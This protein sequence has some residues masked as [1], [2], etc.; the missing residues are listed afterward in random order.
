[1]LAAAGGL[2]FLTWSLRGIQ[3]ADM[4]TRPLQ[5]LYLI[6]G[7]TSVAAFALSLGPWPA[8]ARSRLVLAGTCACGGLLALPWALFG[9]WL[10]AGIFGVMLFHWKNAIAGELFLFALLAILT[11][12]L[13]TAPC[14]HYLH[15]WMV[16]RRRALDGEA[17]RF[18]GLAMSMGFLLPLLV[19][20][21]AELG[22]RRIEQTIVKRFVLATVPDDPESLA[23]WR[24]IAGVHPWAV[25]WEL[26]EHDASTTA[27]PPSEQGRRARA[28]FQ[29]LTGFDFVADPL[30]GD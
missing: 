28:A 18:P 27:P 16:L 14:I 19:G 30:S 11:V 20:G 9:I 25:L 13:T 5:A 12:L 3:V 10:V 21:G 26:T 6:A 23:A 4:G 22:L 24:P 8:S 1:V 15:R 2:T 7:W 17:P 29:V